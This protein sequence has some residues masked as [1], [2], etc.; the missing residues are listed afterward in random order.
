MTVINGKKLATRQTAAV[1]AQGDMPQQVFELFQMALSKGADGVNALEKLVELQ[2][3]IQRRNAETEFHSALAAF[4]ESC[5]AVTKSSTAKIATK[6]GGGYSFTYADLEE[7]ISTVRPHLSRNGFSFTFD[8][9]VEASKLLTCTCTLHHA[10]GHSMSSKF[11]LPI[12]NGSGA[13]DQQKTGGALTYAK[14]QCLISVLGLA[15]ADPEEAGAKAPPVAAIDEAQRANILALLDETK[16]APAKF[17]QRFNLV[18]VAD[19]P[20]TLYA[21]AVRLLEKKRSE[22]AL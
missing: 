5:P 20:V 13:S 15:L 9:S 8:S 1:A 17:C 4:Q 3:K 12:E 2:D 22:A 14:R 21:E 10:H 11:T 6:S 18:S 19:L 7:I 16:V